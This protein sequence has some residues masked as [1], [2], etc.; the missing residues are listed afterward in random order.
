MFLTVLLNILSTYLIC[1]IFENLFIFFIV[2][3][4]LIVLNCEILSVL[5][6][7]NTKSIIIISIAGFIVSFLFWYKLS[8]KIY[9]PKLKDTFKKI[10]NSLKLD[11]TL[12]ILSFFFLFMLLSFLF[13]SIYSIP[14]EPDSRFYHFARIFEFIKQGSFNHFDCDEIRNVIMPVNSEMIYSYFYIFTKNEFSFGLLSYFSFIYLIAGLFNIFSE[15]KI[16]ARKALFS[17]LIFSSLALVLVQIPTHQT[18]ILISSLV[19]ASVYLFIKAKNSNPL[20][21]FS[22]LAYALAIGT[23]TTAIMNFI[24]FFIIIVSYSLIYKKDYKNILK[25]ILF[26]I[27]NF[28]VFSSYNYILNY[29]DFHNF[30][31]PY[32]FRIE[33]K[34]INLIDNFKGLIAD[35]I[36]F[37]F[38]MMRDERATGFTIFETL[39]IL[40]VIVASFFAFFK[41]KNKK[42]KMIS[43]FGMTFALNFLIHLISLDKSVYSVRYFVEYSALVTPAFSFIYFKKFNLLKFLIIPFCIFN[44]TVYSISSSRCPLYAFLILDFNNLKKDIIF[45]YPLTDKEIREDYNMSEEFIE[46]FKK[47]DKILVLNHEQF[48]EIKKLTDYN[49]KIATFNYMIKNNLDNYDYIIVKEN[50]EV[51]NNPKHFIDKFKS[52]DFSYD[53]YAKQ[54]GKRNVPLFKIY[55]FKDTFF[56]KKGFV[57]SKKT[58]LFKTYEKIKKN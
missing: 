5:Q 29:I 8:K 13:L 32:T 11:K 6:I 23:K 36:N 56:N 21:Y 34:T 45:K 14:L 35:F 48:Y 37:P 9:V 53:F 22:S 31:A 55:D 27:F 30:I 41:T 15:L 4:G 38:K 26:L 58:K 47:E 46:K 44:L 20:I 54:V 17:I 7:F 49:T 19:I 3:F 42:I 16:P 57:L 24:A 28:I 51:T 2:L 12:L 43:L 40:S 10:Y 25:F 1:S 50:K 39:V 52:E 33:H 18:D